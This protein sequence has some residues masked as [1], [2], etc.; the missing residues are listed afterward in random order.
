M[1]NAVRV[2]WARC[3]TLSCVYNVPIRRNHGSG[4]LI[5]CAIDS[6]RKPRSMMSQLLAARCGLS[7]GRLRINACR[8]TTRT[9]RRTA[10]SP[11]SHIAACCVTP[12][13]G[14]RR[15]AFPCTP[16]HF[17]GWR[18]GKRIRMT[19]WGSTASLRAWL[20]SAA[21]ARG[22]Q[23]WSNCHFSS[24]TVLLL[25]AHLL[26]CVREGGGGRGRLGR[27]WKELKRK[28][29]AKLVLLNSGRMFLASPRYVA[30]KTCEGIR[31]K[32][33]ARQQVI[34]ALVPPVRMHGHPFHMHYSHQQQQL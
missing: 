5:D 3:V 20:G 10:K 26:M 6:Y 28:E 29:R 4:T 22:W 32:E 8:A 30:T 21:R 27:G 16:S 19:L 15:T 9:C 14:E 24:A 13:G 11:T 23:P 18:R 2:N 1:V 31:C 12:A 34:D 25:P 17:P 7:P 33:F